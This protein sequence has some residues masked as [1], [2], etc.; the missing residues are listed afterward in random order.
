[1]IIFTTAVVDDNIFWD[2]MFY[3]IYNMTTI[4]KFKNKKQKNTQMEWKN[5]VNNPNL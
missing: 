5:L 3:A 1:M 4:K 2:D